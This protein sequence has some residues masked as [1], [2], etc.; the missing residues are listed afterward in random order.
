MAGSLV[1]GLI[2]VLAFAVLQLFKHGGSIF[3]R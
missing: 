1:F 3:D 2:C